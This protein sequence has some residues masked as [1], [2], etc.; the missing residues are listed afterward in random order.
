MIWD[1]G[2]R[3][4]A[5]TFFT[6]SSSDLAAMASYM[7]KG[8]MPGCQILKFKGAPRDLPPAPSNCEVEPLDISTAMEMDRDV[9]GASR[10]P[11]HAFWLG[12][13]DVSGREVRR[14]DELMGYYYISKSVV[15]PMAWNDSRHAKNMLSLAFHDAL[16]NGS[17][18]IVFCVPG[19][20]HDALRFA[21]GAGLRLTGYSHLLAT[22][23]FGRME[24]YVPS[25]AAL[26]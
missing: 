14:G 24:T 11:D 10:E 9:R 12:M 2:R 16:K 25:G 17:A 8:M 21:L 18:E 19:M 13:D 7:R 15:G 20:N 6:W 5:R 3:A 23:P 4:G 26:F 22:G 1:L